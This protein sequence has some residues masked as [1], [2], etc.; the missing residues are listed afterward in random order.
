MGLI[1]TATA[2]GTQVPRG[3]ATSDLDLT[4]LLSAR[5]TQRALI[6]KVGAADGSGNVRGVNVFSGD[7]YA[8]RDNASATKCL[9]WKA[10][11][12]GWVQ[13]DLANAVE[14]SAS[15]AELVEG[16]TL[17]QGGATATILRVAVESGSWATS[18]AG[19]IVI[20]DVTGGPFSAGVATDGATGSCTLTG[21][22]TANTLEP[23]GRFEFENYNFYA[24]ADRFRM[25][26]VD[27]VSRG[28][29]WDGSVF[30]P[31]NTGNTIDTPKHLVVN[32]NCLFYSFAGGSLQRSD[33]GL[34]YEWA[35]GS[36]Y[37]TGDELTGIF[38][39]TGSVLGIVTRNKT[40]ALYDG[41]TSSEVLKTISSEVGGLEWTF[42]RIGSQK[43]LDDRGITQLSSTDR[44]GDFLAA[45]LSQ[46]IEPLINQ[47]KPLVIASI[48]NKT[49]NQYRL[50]FSDG[51]GIDM[52]LN[53][54]KLTGFTTRA[55]SNPDDGSVL[56]INVVV[57]GEDPAGAE[58]LFFGSDTGYL[59]QMDKGVSMDGAAID[60]SLTL[61]YN[62]IKSPSYN[63]QYKKLTLEVDGSVGTTISYNPLFDYSSGQSP[64]DITQQQS[65]DAAGGIWDISVW[66]AFTWAGEDVSQ[67]EGNISGIG[68]NIALQIFS[69]SN[70][71]NPH[72]L[73]GITYHYKYRRLVR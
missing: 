9:M 41:A 5:E 60:A 28:F 62:N 29:E 69:S 55:Y 23:G 24:N 68:R 63:K 33:A 67:V 22:E 54:A 37:G 26:G 73:Y 25:Y 61:A 46:L 1:A 45:T 16:G 59:Y 65:F 12:A 44:F 36:E 11:T 58:V 2:D 42:Q 32:Q 8:F 30:V 31:I 10:T 7:T 35:S 56:P 49:K 38:E 53:G 50:F 15:T 64:L 39:E 18:A 4:Y 19:T 71:A 66:D 40:M 47:K 27:G 57:N 17:T 13:Q 34:P 52:T 20:G 3:A 21:A 70:S 48:I 72:T 43:Y 51:T 14:F 6:A